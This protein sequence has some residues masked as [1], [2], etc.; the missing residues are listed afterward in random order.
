MWSTSNRDVKSPLADSESCIGLTLSSCSEWWPV[1]MHVYIYIEFID[2]NM[3]A[4]YYSNQYYSNLI[5]LID[6]VAT[7][8][9]TVA[10]I[11]RKLDFLSNWM[12]YEQGPVLEG[13]GSVCMSVCTT[14]PTY[15]MIV[16]SFICCCW[17]EVPLISYNSGTQFTQ[18]DGSSQPYDSHLSARKLDFHFLSNWTVFLSILEF[19]FD[20]DF[21]FFNFPFGSKLKGKLW[22]WSYPIQ[23]ERK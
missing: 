2:S 17:R 10:D 19:F 15:M 11:L 22:P 9:A 8:K 4:R 6:V 12:G 18:P 3:S 20:F 5:N 16:I 23:F 1:I 13:V 7:H 21:D 14:G